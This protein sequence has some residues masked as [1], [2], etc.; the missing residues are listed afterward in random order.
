MRAITKYGFAILLAAVPL[1]MQAGQPNHGRSHELTWKGKVTT[2]NPQGK[3][4]TA[5]HWLSKKTFNLGKNCAVA[6]INKKEAALKDL[7]PG[8]QVRIR[9]RDV[10]GVLVADRIAEKPLHYTGKIHA[11]DHNAGTVTMTEPALYKPFHSPE[12]FRL[13]TGCKVVLANG[14]RGDLA[15]L[16]PGDRIR[17]IYEKA[18]GSPV[19]YRIRDDSSTFVGKLNAMDLSA[20]T[21]RA[22]EQ[23]FEVA[24]N[25]RIIVKGE[26]KG[27]LADLALGKEYRF[28]YESVNGVNVVDRIAPAQPTKP[29]QTTTT[30]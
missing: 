21:L 14:E 1:G 23:N 15:A 8:D 5:E 7:R 30:G 11:I 3:T 4:I 12:K 22:R 29:S 2:V 6:T 17:V 20:R 10:E 25:C 28:T 18:G 19:A 9:Y 24:D 13:A 16:Q 27:H 26:Q